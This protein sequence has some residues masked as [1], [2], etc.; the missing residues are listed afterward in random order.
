MNKLKD[1]L[2]DNQFNF[3]NIF[4]YI[5]ITAVFII[6]GYFVIRYYFIDNVAPFVSEYDGQHYEVRKVGDNENK[7]TAANYLAILNSKINKLIDYMNLHNLPDP[8]T[9]KRLYHRWMECELKETN[10][11]EKSAAYTL[12]KSAEIRICIR[13]QNDNFENINTSMFV[14][15]HELSHVASISYG[16]EEEFRNNFSY[17][18][19]LASSLGIYKPENFKQT[20]KMYCGTAI[21]TTPCSENTCTFN[22]LK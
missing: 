20:P 18:T 2:K 9:A 22:N 11:N 16:H 21:N 3:K 19:H 4:I 10:S 15:L 12:N 17:I 7:Q 8:D 6:L 5:L 13:D 1:K 14:I